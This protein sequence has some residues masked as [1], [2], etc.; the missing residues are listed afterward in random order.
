MAAEI[1]NTRQISQ[2]AAA[3][4]LNFGT[5][6]TAIRSHM[7]DEDAQ[8]LLLECCVQQRERAPNEGDQ[9]SASVPGFVFKDPLKKKTKNPQTLQP[10]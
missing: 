1:S 5:G 4:R 7:A 2:H 10:V 8:I 3:D 9:S 6:S